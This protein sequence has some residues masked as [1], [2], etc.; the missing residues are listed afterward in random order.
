[1]RVKKNIYFTECEKFMKKLR[2]K[3]K[4]LILFFAETEYLHGGT[5]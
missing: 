3:Q 1:M 2:A 5:T 4:K